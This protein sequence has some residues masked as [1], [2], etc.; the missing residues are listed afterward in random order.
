VW[1]S[2]HSGRV[3]RDKEPPRI[4]RDGFTLI[5]LLVVIAIIAVLIALLLPAVQKVRAAANRASCTNNLH[6]IGLAIHNYHDTLGTL[7]R[8]RLCPDWLFNG[9]VDLYC[10]S[11][12]QPNGSSA[13]TYT[14]DNEV[15][16]AAYDNKPPATATHAAR[17]D[18]PRGLLW[19]YIEQNQ[20]VYKC[21][22]GLDIDPASSTLGQPYQ[23]SYGMNYVTNGPN[24]KR[25]T[26]LI[27]GNG[28]SNIVVVWDHGKTPGCAYS[29]YAAPRGPWLFDGREMP[30]DIA[31]APLVHYPRRHATM[32]NV[33]FCDGHALTMQQNDL[34]KNLF[35]AFQTE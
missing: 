26:D 6:Q 13:T 34:F 35:Y 3:A 16:W 31:A 27:N 10:E 17:D 30:A 2:E 5:E 19:P 24:G 14:G 18:Y 23:V 4:Q 20:K 7:P 32:F 25:L 12:G 15:W 21:P 22:D 11:L 1:K 28:S 29:T 9:E 33:L 8:Y